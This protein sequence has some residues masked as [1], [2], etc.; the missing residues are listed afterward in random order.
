VSDTKP[1]VLNKQAVTI[2]S[3]SS[4]SGSGA[5]PLAPMPSQNAP[6]L[7][8]ARAGPPAGGPGPT[9]RP[10]PARATETLRSSYAVASAAQAVS[11]LVANALDAGATV[12]DVDI[13]LQRHRLA[14]SDNG[15]HARQRSPTQTQS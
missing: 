9:I 15:T 14:V 5:P 4:S 3:S 13:D 7:N 12:V 11:E 8:A 6:P 2:D 1:T 10:L